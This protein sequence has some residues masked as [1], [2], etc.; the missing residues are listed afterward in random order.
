MI[1][2][3]SQ[4][5]ISEYAT[6]ALTIA[7]P[8]GTDYTQGV[9]V[10]KTIPAK[11]WNWLFRATTKRIHQ[12]KTDAS[13]MF[14]ELKN[15]VTDAGIIP[16]PTDNTQLAQAASVLSVR[17]VDSYIQEKK[18]GYFSNWTTENCTGI[19]QFAGS[20]IVTIDE[21]KAIPNSNNQA[22]YMRLK[23]HTSSPAADH[24]LH[25][26]S[27]DLVN[28]H[29]ITA[30]GG[31]ELQSVDITY[32]KG[33]YYF[34][35]SVKDVHDAQLYYSDDAAL[36]YFARSFSEYGCVA[37]RIAAN[38]LW[39]ISASSQTYVDVT[40]YS[41]YT[42]DGNS[43]TSAGTIFRNTANT[44]DEIGEVLAFQG[45]YIIG[46]KITTDGVSWSTIITDWSNSA[47]SNAILT[48]GNTAI[49]QFNATE[50]AWYLLS[51]PLASPVK[52]LGTWV[53]EYMGPESNI[54][55]YDSA[56]DYAGITLDGDNFTKFSIEFPSDPL[57]QFFKC[58]SYYFLGNY[59]SLDMVTWDAITLPLGA[60]VVQYSGIGYY[61]IA[62]NFFSVDYG[63]S[64]VQGMA[65]GQAFCAVPN[66]I[67]DTATCMAVTIRSNVVLRCMT[68]NGVNRVIGTTL[69][70]K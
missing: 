42:S 3:L 30:P 26:T 54:L 31:A 53:F 6:N 19:P 28:W 5:D 21:L 4:E 63:V 66:Y 45:S 12:A 58:G 2:E 1:N 37:L 16:D 20:D 34:L 40:Y 69:Y 57:A 50:E 44:V 32:F 14:T 56:D 64:W 15:T 68:F 47:Y 7:E 18:R 55:V 70:L 10:G 59:K 38:V 9:Q 61:I 41:Y 49:L 22:F 39:M 13:N 35:Y 48:A 11:W 65:A 60:T 52:K 43:W 8:L 33:R 24:Y 67:S 23:Q 46:N 62:G 25:F 29:E 27:T 51:S 17:G 36:W